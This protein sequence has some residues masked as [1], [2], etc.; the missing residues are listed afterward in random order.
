MEALRFLCR[1][2]NRGRDVGA[3]VA[4]TV[5]FVAGGVDND[6]AAFPFHGADEGRDN[7]RIELRAGVLVDLGDDLRDVHALA[8]RPVGCHR[9]DSIGQSQDAGF[10]RDLLAD[11]AIRIALAIV[12]LVVVANE[13][14]DIVERLEFSQQIRPNGDMVLDQVVLLQGQMTRFE[15]DDLW[16]GQ[17]ADVVH[18]AGPAQQLDFVWRQAHLFGRQYRIAG[19]IDGVLYHVWIAQVNGA[20]QSEKQLVVQLMDGFR[21]LGQLLIC[22]S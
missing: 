15:E 9:L 7:R 3:D 14:G 13:R 12:T 22:L 18:E 8:I 2:N 16:D 1:R 20:G 6:A 19:D 10:Q 21:L 4:Y 5:H 17:L 11:Q